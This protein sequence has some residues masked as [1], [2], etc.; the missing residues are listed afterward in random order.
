MTSVRPPVRSR[1]IW[2]SSLGVA[3][4]ALLFLL[5]KPKS[6]A[7]GPPL[8]RLDFRPS[9]E[10]QAHLATLR[11]SLSSSQ[12]RFED[13]QTRNRANAKLFMFLAG[14]DDDPRVVRASLEALSRA[15]S[16]RSELKE[17][18][19][20][21][22]ATVLARALVSTDPGILHA[23]FQAVR[24][25]LMA[26]GGAP[27]LEQVL[28]ELS[29]NSSPPVKR[30][31]AIEALDLLPP[32][33][34][35]GKILDAFASSLDAS[36]PYVRV[37]ALR[38]LEH[39]V[40]S[41]EV[42]QAPPWLNR[43]WDLSVDIQPAVRGQALSTLVAFSR[44]ADPQKLGQRLQLGLRDPSP[45]VRA[46]AAA[47]LGAI[48]P[49]AAIHDLLPLVRDFESSRVELLGWSNFDGTKGSLTL[50]IPGRPRV[51]DVALFAIHQKSGGAF[52]LKIL[53]PMAP[54]TALL[55]NAE[56]VEKWY[57]SASIPSTGDLGS[58]H[59]PLPSPEP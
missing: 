37:N 42:G 18:P 56:L 58:I 39:S 50:H 13:A 35:N 31:L 41:I 51:S 59:P 57:A 6:E 19:D 15:Y 54:D 14:T 12:A 25:P 49:P 44:Y 33:K 7:P 26:E 9:S 40:E 38:A 34:R 32:Q 46:V 52:D 17:V 23:A 8:P 22:L 30:Y 4:G 5:P 20:R 43:V 36:E 11:A 16:S 2:A 3:A 28:A 48:G 10:D 47:A 1:L 21:D 27:E 55:A 24:I 29:L 45:Y 53:P